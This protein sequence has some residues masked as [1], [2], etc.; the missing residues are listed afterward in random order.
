MPFGSRTYDQLLN[1]DSLA[2]TSTAEQTNLTTTSVGSQKI[3]DL[4][5]GD[6]NFGSGGLLDE[7]GSRGV[8]G[9]LLDGLDGTSLVNGV[10]SDVHD[11]T[12]SA[13]AD[14]NQNRGAGI[15]DLVSSNK[16][17]GT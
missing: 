1:E 17:L 5:T 8:D 16:T 4:D 12:E 3:D 11:T 13:G 15:L 7:F 10:T 6:Q 2:D 14:G 9:S